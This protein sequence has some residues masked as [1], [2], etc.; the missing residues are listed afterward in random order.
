MAP[1]F[2]IYLD[3]RMFMYAFDF[4]L[5]YTKEDEA[6]EPFFPGIVPRTM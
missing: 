6:I 5:K 3:F 1:V 2:S 4:F